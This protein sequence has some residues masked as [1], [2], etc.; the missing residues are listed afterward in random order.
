MT[1]DPLIVILNAG[2]FSGEIH[3]VTC[4]LKRQASPLI[5]PMLR[6]AQISSVVVVVA[7]VVVVEH[8]HLPL[9]KPFSG[10]HYITGRILARKSPT[11]GQST[12]SFDWIWR[13]SNQRYL[14]IR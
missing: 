3:E 14:W 8:S 10:S 9:S 1:V 13:F 5:Q 7:V 11:L 4:C 2:P 12:C 6:L